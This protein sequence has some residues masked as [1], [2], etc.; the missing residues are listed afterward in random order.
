[1]K[2]TYGAR[3]LE[4]TRK[5]RLPENQQVQQ[6][7][8]DIS[9]SQDMV[10]SVEGDLQMNSAPFKTKSLEDPRL[11][12]NQ[13]STGVNRSP[14]IAKEIHVNLLRLKFI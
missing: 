12:N 14:A 11:H 3:D 4:A 6:A 8:V 2:R 9:C 7:R 13:N 1:M 10:P 5:L